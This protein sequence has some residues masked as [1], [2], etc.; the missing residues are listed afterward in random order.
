MNNIQ[1]V[2]D[3]NLCIA[4]GVCAAVCPVSAIS[5]VNTEQKSVA[6]VDHEICK[7]C[8]VC[9]HVC[10]YNDFIYP[11][12]KNKLDKSIMGEYHKI[13]CVQ[14]RNDQ[15]LDKSTSGGVITTLVSQLLSDREYD[16]AA[17]VGDTKNGI[18]YSELV[19]SSSDVINYCKSKY[20]TV[21]YENIIKYIL[22]NQEKKIIFIGTGCTV[23]AFLNTIKLKKLKRENYL[24]I[25]LF[26]DKTMYSSV[27]NY[28]SHHPSCKGRSLVSI[29]FR[30]K[31]SGGWPGNLM[32]HFSKNEC[33]ELPIKERGAV[34]D[35]YMPERCLYC[36][37]KLNVNCDI[38]VGD[39]YI[40][41]NA[42]NRGVSSVIIRS[43]LGNKVWDK[44]N[45]LFNV[46]ADDEKALMES[47]HISEKC[48]NLSYAHIKG[49]Y[50]E[51][52]SGTVKKDVE[53]NY[54][55]RL[56]KLSI[57]KSGNS[58]KRINTDIKILRLRSLIKR[59]QNKVKKLLH[60]A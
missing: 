10:P 1:S 7:D 9:S 43:E 16:A 27:F 22:K 47:Q 23:N 53:Y 60:R 25:G 33:A 45:R 32:L 48:N 24:I 4:C 11:V 46:H 40:K 44:Y 26:C 5:I 14:S 30:T 38:A 20:V 21:S 37:N 13:L 58:F 8:K 31:E 42:D 35:Y 18:T 2:I 15:M 36:L 29:D 55:I 57:D 39:N 49:L 54:S 17:L 50:G 19:D 34:K 12:D 52:H 56:H 59:G 51:N 6:Q 3:Q 41:K 28:F